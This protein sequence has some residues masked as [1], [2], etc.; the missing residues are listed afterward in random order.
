MPLILLRR[1]DYFER[2]SSLFGATFYLKIRYGAKQETVSI[3]Y[4]IIEN[5]ESW[6]HEKPAFTRYFSH[7]S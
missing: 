4:S 5:Q 2:K 7:V 6:K 3:N 1:N